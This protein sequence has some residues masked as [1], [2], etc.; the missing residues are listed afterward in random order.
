MRDET[1]WIRDLDLED[2]PVNPFITLV[3]HRKAGKSHTARHIYDF[4]RVRDGF[5]ET[6]V[7]TKTGAGGLWDGVV[8]SKDRII[9]KDFVEFMRILIECQE[10]VRDEFGAKRMP[11]IC[12]VLDDVIGHIP[13]NCQELIDLATT[14]RWLNI[15]VLLLT[16]Y[17]HSFFPIMR[18][19]TDLL[20]VFQNISKS[21]GEEIA[22]E[23]AY[24]SNMGPTE[25]KE[26]YSSIAVG[27]ATLAILRTSKAT[28]IEDR[29][30]VL[31]APPNLKQY[32][33][34]G[35]RRTKRRREECTIL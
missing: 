32:E 4:L 11:K 15:T 34:P 13:A 22:G 33:Q 27:F 25:F 1:V 16:Q 17:Y 14:G 3:G 5:D 30:F 10:R 29:F 6:F 31:E 12:L 9:R 19:N 24:G 20:C 18:V 35:K 26:M 21:T 2:I 23:C 7:L 28:E 8:A